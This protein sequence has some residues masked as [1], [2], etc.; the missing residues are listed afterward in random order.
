MVCTFTSC[1]VQEIRINADGTATVNT[2]FNLILAADLTDSLELAADSVVTM[3]EL[4]AY[5]D[6]EVIEDLNIGRDSSNAVVTFLTRE[7]DSLGNYMDPLAGYTPQTVLTDEYFELIGP[8]G[9]ANWEDDICGCTNMLT[10]QLTLTFEKTIARIETENSYIKQLN[11][12][13][14]LI[15]TSVGELN[16]NGAE[17]RLKVYFK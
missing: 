5:Y 11:A 14:V 15:D 3:D 8:M 1:A 17:N 2:S 12:H 10:Y 4:Y 9:D 13:Q 6:S 7:V 16:Y